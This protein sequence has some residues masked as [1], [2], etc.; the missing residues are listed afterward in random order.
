MSTDGP[1]APRG[2]GGNRISRYTRE[3]RR[4]FRTTA[5]KAD[6]HEKSRKVLEDIST[7]R[8]FITA[9]LEKHLSMPEALNAR[10]YPVVGLD[11]DLNP[12]YHLVAN[13]WIPLPGRETNVSTKAIHHH[14]SMLLTTVTVFGAGYEHWLFTK[15]AVVDQTRELY[16]MQ[17]ADRRRHGLH[18]IAFVDAHVP[19]LPLYPGALTITLAMWSSSTATTWKDRV[20]RIPMLKRNELILKRLAVRAGIARSFDLKVIEYFDFYPVDD[21]FKGMQERV[22]FDL[23]PNEDHLPSLFH[24]LQE[25]G[26]DGVAPLVRAHLDSGRVPVAN[27]PMVRRLLGDLERGRAIGGRLSACHLGVPHATF[28]TRDIERAVRVR[29]GA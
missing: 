27:A 20:K 28:T 6:A 29:S 22:E 16:A 19:H 11:I 9:V 12:D 21:G 23:G 2:D 26:N 1:A 25:T 7:D 10:H 14:G 24:I 17:I 5:S 13:C 8:G 15:P 4:I 3:L 18:D